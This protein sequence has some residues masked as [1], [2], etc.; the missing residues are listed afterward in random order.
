MGTRKNRL[1][2]AVLTS[3]HNLCFGAKIRKNRYTPA[4]PSFAMQKWGS[5]GYTCH[6]RVFLMGM[7]S[8]QFKI[9]SV[10]KS[11]SNHTQLDRLEAV[12]QFERK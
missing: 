12:K 7:L 1:D 4:Y 3:T 10:A 6:G 8:L 9:Y 5:M 2:K 11:I